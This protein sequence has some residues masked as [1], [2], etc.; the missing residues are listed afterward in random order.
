MKI[1]LI[2][3][4]FC[5]VEERRRVSNQTLRV[6]YPLAILL[7]TFWGE[8][9]T[10]QMVVGDQ[11]NRLGIIN[12]S[13]LEKKPGSTRGDSMAAFL[14]SRFGGL[15]PSQHRVFQRTRRFPSPKV[16]ES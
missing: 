8:N 15:L 14:S 5:D 3:P 1:M 16:I 10:F 13:Q 7:V 9:V 4:D 11:P 6:I 12:H 2:R